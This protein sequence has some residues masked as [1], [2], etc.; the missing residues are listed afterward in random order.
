IDTINEVMAIQQNGRT[1]RIEAEKTLYQMEADLKQKL[2]Q[3]NL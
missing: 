2:L 3:T 1:Q